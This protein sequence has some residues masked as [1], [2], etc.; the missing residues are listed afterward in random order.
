MYAVP[1][2]TLY[3]IDFPPNFIMLLF[4]GEK[5]ESS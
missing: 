5:A 3:K 4:C 2:S 1:L